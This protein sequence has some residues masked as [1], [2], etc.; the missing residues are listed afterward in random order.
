MSKSNLLTV[1]KN[2]IFL[3]FWLVSIFAFA[4][5]YLF[6]ELYS[7][8]GLEIPSNDLRRMWKYGL[9]YDFRSASLIYLPILLMGLAV[10]SVSSWWGKWK[11]LV[12][13]L[14]FMLAWLSILLVL[15]NYFYYQTFHNY[16]D[17]FI[18]GLAED[19]TKNILLSMFHDYPVFKILGLSLVLSAPVY[20]VTKK[21][22]SAKSKVFS[23]SGYVFTA[24][25]L[26]F[27]TLY[28]LAARGSTGTFPLRR[29][30][31]QVS[32]ITFVNQVTPNAIMSLNWAFSD[33]KKSDRFPPVTEDEHT[34]LMQDLGLDSIY[35]RTPENTFLEKNKPH[36]VA[37]VM[38]S[39][40]SNM[41]EFDDEKENNLLGRLRPH[42]KEDFL[43]KRFLS[44]SNGT[45][46]SLA[47]LYFHSPAQSI[48]YSTYQN[49][50]LDNPFLTYKK[51]GYK[52]IYIYSGNLMWVNYANYLPKQG[53]DELYDQNSLMNLYPEASSNLEAWGVPDEYAFMLAER[54]LN[55]ATE[56]LFINILTVTNHPPYKKPSTYMAQTVSSQTG[57]VN[58]AEDPIEN[59]QEILQTYQYAADAL[60][61]FMDN[62]KASQAAQKT[63]VGVVGDHQ[64]RRIKA[65]YPKEQMLDRAVPFYIYI[66]QRIQKNLNLHFEPL[67]VG[68]HKDMMPTLMHVSLSNAEYLALGGRNLLAEQDDPNRAFAYNEDIWLE[69]N[70]AYT[71][72][73]QASFYSW[74]DSEGLF[75]NGT[76]IQA[77]ERQMVRMKAYNRLLRW[78]IARQVNK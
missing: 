31:A 18:F 73:K 53:V 21:Q 33:R 10:F 6:T 51:S 67:R 8:S 27:V 24:W 13:T 49:V 12:P 28:F 75:L 48:S 19:D 71:I 20:W 3:V 25:V 58:H 30:D 60:G 69:N 76:P 64:M 63:I 23:R 61:G 40:G 38:E 72:A 16:F 57:F 11:K 22:Y 52:V 9:R 43:F 78:N 1:F 37:V 46:P 55:E 35:T 39:F 34:A 42:F 4:R 77:E 36:V 65:I 41:L 15:S 7:Q 56:P 2:L 44:H 59:Q 47:G 66:P 29:N 17:I 14:A 68:S 62:L 5:F 54:L 26:V 50:P 74:A 70:G 45:A 32:Q